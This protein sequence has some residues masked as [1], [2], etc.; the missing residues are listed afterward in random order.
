M[1]A[2]GMAMMSRDDVI[3]DEES[4]DAREVGGSGGRGGNAGSY[5][6]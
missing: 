3:V 4:H 2:I 6:G 5:L 1:A